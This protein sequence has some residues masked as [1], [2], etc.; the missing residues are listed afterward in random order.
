MSDLAN[1]FVY[2]VPHQELTVQGS[3]IVAAGSSG[4]TL[5]QHYAGLAMQ[6]I[7]AKHLLH[8]GGTNLIDVRAKQ[9]VKLA[10]ALI[11]ALES[12]P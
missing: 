5:R 3:Q 4:I 9:A 10:D 7:V 11:A 6:G 2:P 12:K 8:E 1:S